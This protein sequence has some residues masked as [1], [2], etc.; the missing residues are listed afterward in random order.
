L[1]HP[2][3]RKGQGPKLLSR[4]LIV[5][6][7]L[8][9]GHLIVSGFGLLISIVA[10]MS[11]EGQWVITPLALSLF[12]PALIADALGVGPEPV[13]SLLLFV[14]NSVCWVSVVYPG[15][16]CGRRLIRGFT[17]ACATQQAGSPTRSFDSPHPR[18]H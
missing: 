4:R 15:W 6:V 14:V 11:A 9:S 10:A 13:H 7:A 3:Q 17:K 2:E 16:L 18:A 12:F 1:T 8:V 5:F